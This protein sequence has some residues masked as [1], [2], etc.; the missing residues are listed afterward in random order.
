MHPVDH[1][2]PG[3]FDNL[4]AFREVIPSLAGVDPP[5][6]AAYH[7]GATARAGRS[8]NTTSTPGAT[9]EISLALFR[10]HSRRV[11]G[12]IMPSDI[13]VVIAC[14]EKWVLGRRTL[15]LIDEEVGFLI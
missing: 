13:D 14:T 15:Q 7:A 12:G 9:H 11:S 2:Q 10:G 1:H 8:S 6:D 5:D 3:L 4:V